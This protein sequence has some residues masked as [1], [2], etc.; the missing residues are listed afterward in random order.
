MDGEPDL[1][2][3]S[4]IPKEPEC[5]E[6]S[7][8]S[9]VIYL[10]IREENTVESDCED[11]VSLIIQDNSMLDAS[12]VLNSGIKIIM[13]GDEQYFYIP[14]EDQ[15]VS[16]S[17][18]AI[19]EPQLIEEDHKAAA[20]NELLSSALLGEISD[21]T[22]P[23]EMIMINNL[24]DP[25]PV[26]DKIKKYKCLYK[27][28]EKVYS[29]SQHLTVHMRNHVNSKPFPCTYE[30]CNKKFA[31]NYSLTTHH[32]THTGE[33]PYTCPQCSKSFK[34]SG[35]LMKHVR[36]HTGE[37]PFICPVEGCGKAFTTSNI[38]KVHVRS[39]T[40]ERPYICDYPNCGK[41]FASCTNYK[42]HARIHSGEKPYVCTVEG[43]DK[44][45]TEY[46][47]LY[48]HQAVHRL[49]KPHDCEYCRQKFKSDYTLNVH[50]KMKHRVLVSPEGIQLLDLESMGL[51]S[52]VS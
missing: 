15:A 44:T 1:P 42:N 28:C 18:E 13:L 38:R 16:E 41:A 40:G 22:D 48:K 19:D 11:P 36:I 26:R 50:R 30:G 37:K 25:N 39:H 46:S 45:F 7:D 52:F 14:S 43:C 33:K 31:T 47:S 51:S 17:I 27:G 5:T 29:S 23:I 2:M 35:D 34:T 9:G 21:T 32:R 12:A 8:E 20:D 3:F 6:D 49:E 10:T 4:L 24:E